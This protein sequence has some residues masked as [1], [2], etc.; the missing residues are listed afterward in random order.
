M[1]YSAWNSAKVVQAICLPLEIQENKLGLHSLSKFYNQCLTEL[2]VCNR[3]GSHYSIRLYRQRNGDCI[4][5]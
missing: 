1:N 2:Q 5:H 3:M 4:G